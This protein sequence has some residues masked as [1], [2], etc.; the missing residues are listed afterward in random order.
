MHWSAGSGSAV[1]DAFTAL[2]GHVFFEFYNIKEDGE[3]P[4]AQIEPRGLG[5][6]Y[7]HPLMKIQLSIDYLTMSNALRTHEERDP[8]VHLRLNFSL[9]ISLVHEVA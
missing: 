3:F 4:Y 7:E 2:A 6:D 5:P 1:L 8:A 9:A